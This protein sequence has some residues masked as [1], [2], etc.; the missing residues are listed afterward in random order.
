MPI[1]KSRYEKAVRYEV[2]LDNGEDYTKWGDLILGTAA[3]ISEST[4]HISGAKSVEFDKIAGST[5]VYIYKQFNDGIDLGLFANEG[6]ICASVYIPDK[7]NVEK[8]FIGFI[9]DNMTDYLLFEEDT[10]EDGWNHVRMLCADGDQD[11]AG[12][13][14]ESIKNVF[15]GLQFFAAGDTLNN[16][17]VDSVRIQMVS[18]SGGSSSVSGDVGL[19]DLSAANTART[20][21]TEVL[22]VQM[23]DQG[24]NVGVLVSGTVNVA[25]MSISNGLQVGALCSGTVSSSI[26]NLP[27]NYSCIEKNPSGPEFFFSP[28]DFSATYTSTSGIT[29]A[30][31]PFTPAAEQFVGVWSYNASSGLTAWDLVTRGYSWD[32]GTGLLNVGGASWGASD[33]FKVCISGQQKGYTQVTDSNRF[34]EIAP[35]DLKVVEESLV[36]T[37]NV[38]VQTF[39]PS[40]DGMQM[41]GYA[42][43]SL[44]GKLIQGDAVETKLTVWATNDEDSTPA[45]R[46]WVYLYGYNWGTNTTVTGVTANASTTT[47]AWQFSNLNFKYVRC[48]VDPGDATNTVIIKARRKAL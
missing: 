27:T 25:N 39:Y 47:F 35:L 37:T 41:L 26:T 12:V 15:V 31:L 43:L 1:D 34:Y 4:R 29:L 30:G 19:S 11:G 46:D 9:E 2:T 42:D 13:N 14:W 48:Q 18:T 20:A 28:S 45:N 24:G 44:T 16:I 3:N 7:T 32:S 10:V 38:T 17:C 33:K 5:K 40:S 22:P 36:D 23:L 6:H 21:A 8:I